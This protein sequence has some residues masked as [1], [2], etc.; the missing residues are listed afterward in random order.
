MLIHLLIRKPNKLPKKWFMGP[1]KCLRHHTVFNVFELVRKLPCIGC[2]IGLWLMYIFNHDIMKVESI[3]PGTKTYCFFP[4]KFL[5][6]ILF[7]VPFKVASKRCPSSFPSQDSILNVASWLLLAPGETNGGC[8][9][10]LGAPWCSICFGICSV[11]SSVL[12]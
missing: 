6:G 2:C 9:G 4:R 12:F 10:H 3:N 7:E 1:K 8:W 11:A 5:H